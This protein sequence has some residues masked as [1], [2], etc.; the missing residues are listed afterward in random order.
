MFF[1]EGVIQVIKR[2]FLS[3][4]FFASRL[5]RDDL[6]TGRKKSQFICFHKGFAVFGQPLE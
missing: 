6:P 5:L 4:H 1:V 2:P 3:L